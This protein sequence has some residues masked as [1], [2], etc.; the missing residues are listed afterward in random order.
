MIW[1][2]TTSVLAYFLNSYYTE[3]LI[4][5]TRSGSKRAISVLIWRPLAHGTDRMLAGLFPASGRPR[6]VGLPDG[7]WRRRVS[8]ALSSR[9]L[10]ALG[11]LAGV[12]FRQPRL[13]SQPRQAGLGRL[14]TPVCP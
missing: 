10:P 2:T 13:N 3:R 8:G 1:Q 9:R 4:H 7:V 12:A 6:T 5:T 14:T 11:E